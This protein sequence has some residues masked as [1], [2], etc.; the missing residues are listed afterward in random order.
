MSAGGVVWVQKMG[1]NVCERHH[2]GQ[3]IQNS[4][5]TSHHPTNERNLVPLDRYKRS[6]LLL[7]EN[8][9]LEQV[10]VTRQSGA[11]NKR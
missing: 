2:S 8:G 9:L 5:N 1:S 3:K 7:P 4:R 11:L 10:R 6:R